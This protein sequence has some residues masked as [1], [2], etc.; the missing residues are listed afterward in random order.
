MRGSLR[1]EKGNRVKMSMKRKISCFKADFRTPLR[2]FSGDKAFYTIPDEICVVGDMT[3]GGV[4]KLVE[5]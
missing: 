2:I 4:L 3:K 1:E 5:K